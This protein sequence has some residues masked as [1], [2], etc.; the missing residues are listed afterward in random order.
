MSL[1]LSVAQTG[2]GERGSETFVAATQQ[3][4]HWGYLALTVCVACAFL[5]NLRA[6][7]AGVTKRG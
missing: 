2:A 1:F 6:F 5:A 3:G 7:A 4:A